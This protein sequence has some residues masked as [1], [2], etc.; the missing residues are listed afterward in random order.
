MKEIFGKY[1]DLESNIVYTVLKFTEDIVETDTGKI[2]SSSSNYVTTCGC[3]LEPKDDCL[4]AFTFFDLHDEG[5]DE[6]VDI[7]KIEAT[8]YT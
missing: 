4:E 8:S 7:H 6:S 1:R 5:I 3:Q 2:V